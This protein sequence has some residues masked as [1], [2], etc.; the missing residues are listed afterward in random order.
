MREV[1]GFIHL[2]NHTE[3]S[4]LDGAMQIDRLVELAQRYR[5]G[6]LAIT[7]HGNLFGAIQFYRAAQ[8]AGLKPILGMEAYVAPGDR[9]E[10]RIYPHIPESNF[11]LTLLVQD[12][13]GYHNLIKLA[14]LAS[15]EGFYY[16][17]RID[18]ELL[19]RYSKGLVGLSGCLKGEVPYRLLRDEP[20]KA[21]QAAAEYRSILGPENFFLEIQDLGLRETQK[22]IPL[23]VSLSKR[24]GI[25]VVATNDCHYL[26]REDHLAH[27]VL[28]CIQT[29]KKL[30]QPGRIR[31][32]TREG[33]FKSPEE[34]E[35]LFAELPEA[36]RNTYRVAERCNLLLDLS[37]RS[38]HLPQYPWP[39]G[40]DSA[41]AYLSHLARQGLSRRYREV[42]PEIS[43]RLEHELSIIHRMGFSG[44][45]LIAKDIVDFARANS[46]GVGPGR[47]SA[48]GSLVLYSIG[49]TDIDP[50]RYGLI[51]ERFLNPDR[52]TLPDI[53]IDFADTRRDEV[54]EYIR[55]RYG[56][57]NVA[58]V[59]TFGTM[60]ARAV[61]RDVGRVLEVPNPE[62]DRIAKLIPFGVSLVEA[63]K[64]PT[65]KELV[66]SSP[67]YEKL[68]SIARQLEG[69]VRHASIHASGV[70]IAPRPL[71]ELVPLYRLGSG[72]VCTGYDMVS[73][74]AC[75]L[76][77]LDILGLR[78]LSVVDST[79]KVIE[80]EGH[81]IERSQVRLDDPKAYKL[82][83]DAETVGIF[84]L[85]SFG[86]REILR[87]FKPERIE[88]L[89]AV[90]SLYR[91]GP[92]G[93][94]NLV[95]FIERKQGKKITYLHPLLE[96]VLRETYGV[97]LY[98]E[99]VM[100]IAGLIAGFEMA[101]ADRL[102]RAMAKKDPDLMGHLRE[103]FISGAKVRGVPG[104]VAEK[105]F[106][107][108]T[109][110]AGYGFNKSHS[111]GY[112]HLSYLTAYLKANYPKEFMCA[113]LNSELGN[114]DKLYKFLGEARRLSIP[115]LPPDINRSYYEFTLEDEGIRFGLGGIK[116][117]GKGAAEAV[118]EARRSG[119][120]NSLFDFLK[121][122]RPALN[123][124]CAESLI[125]AGALDG[126]NPD[127][128]ALLSE[129]PDAIE[130]ASSL[131]QELLLRQ[132]SFFD[133]PPSET[134]PNPHP[135]RNSP[136]SNLPLEKEAF[137]FYFSYHP[138]EPYRDLYR[139]L[140]LQSSAQLEDM[141]GDQPVMVG[142]VISGLR[143]K[144]DR[145]NRD[146]CILKLEDFDGEV[147][148]FLFAEPYQSS[149]QLLGADTPV[150]AKGRTWVREGESARLVA[151]EIIP[152]S[153]VQNYIH[154]LTLSIRPDGLDEAQLHRLKERLLSHPGSCRVLV[155]LRKP[156][157]S[158]TQVLRLSGITVSPSSELLGELKAILGEGSVRLDLR[159]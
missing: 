26:R 35:R 149:R 8:A 68:I 61:V 105:I 148:L 71:M 10:R 12:E 92:L 44:Y 146:Y 43:A 4:L 47:G 65:L 124:K 57:E 74:G 20:E 108:I 86:M 156:E 90:I 123:R 121:R 13:T 117:V 141:G 32:E 145:N 112:A 158:Q 60:Q 34:M 136:L 93:S 50:I 41:H 9:K 16:R 80:L 107:A 111:T 31:F 150:V 67:K 69:M 38:L 28:L 6:A 17:P 46:I 21:C 113:L 23:M 66:S 132:T 81:R 22:V 72:E 53:D 84:Q 144:R 33:Y 55:H 5:M 49:I 54:I 15:L 87:R 62:V 70:V 89:I 88:D 25:P 119:K 109:P 18:K 45:F 99:Q 110:F 151:E 96:P 120:F 37:G 106:D 64:E 139:A 14:S 98:Q 48:A 85:E 140:R 7:D 95:D 39:E 76:P 115:L 27:D 52:M 77:K 125:K 131:R 94:V 147:E 153:Q 3:Y 73:L 133:P 101:Q 114:S 83:Q 40:F 100:Q 42:T 152:F 142:G 135:G 97:I 91:P 138:L 126:I 137:G 103:E 51:F 30:S 2:H 128:V 116:N 82:L 129:L 78:T 63:L 118:V 59:I 155:R 127:R 19:A 122:T 58:Q 130:R 36:V 154:S 102:R 29:G 24:L 104:R 134:P 143:V 157:D 11:H 56:A 1:G 79:F 159:I 75:G